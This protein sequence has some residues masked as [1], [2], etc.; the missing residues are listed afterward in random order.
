[1]NKRNIIMAL[2]LIAMIGIFYF[3]EASVEKGVS[4]NIEKE[5]VRLFEN[6]DPSNV[7]TITISNLKKSEKVTFEKSGEEWTVK[8]KNCLADKNSMNR[9]LETI[10]KI[11]PGRNMGEWK[12]EYMA[13]HG[14]NQGLE[15]SVEG[16][17]FL[18]G[19][20]SGVATALKDGNTLY[21]SPFMEKYVFEKY[22][23]NWCEK[24]P[25]KKPEEQKPE[26]SK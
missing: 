21:F 15:I 25:E 20:R 16:K 2:T 4:R 3:K 18:I 17:T 7:K 1:M 11:R 5:S 6:F 10:P 12:D 9:I 26:N 13:A 22:D 24:E 8:E 23:G 19:S 14:F